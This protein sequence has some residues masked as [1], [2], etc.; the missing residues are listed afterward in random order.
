[1]KK[2]TL[3]F[4][5]L[6]IS[7]VIKAQQIPTKD[8]EIAQ[9][10]I[11]NMF[12]A[13]SMRDSVNLKTY[14]ATDITFYEYGEIWDLETLISK[15]IIQ[16]MATDFKRTNTFEFIKTKIDKTAAWLTYRLSSII[17]KDGKEV[18]MQW[19]ETVILE[20]QKNQWKVKHLHSTLI[21]KT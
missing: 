19:L 4:I 18:K 17:K 21:N 13:L 5:V 8:Q 11:I 9:Q 2:I 15:A 20:K 10:T 3:L 14:C 16:N 1:M 6:A 12:E 7:T